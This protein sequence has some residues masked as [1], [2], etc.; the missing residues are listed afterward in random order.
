MG[1]YTK[2]KL[3]LQRLKDLDS[4]YIEVVESEITRCEEQEFLARLEAQKQSIETGEFAEGEYLGN[5][6]MALLSEDYDKALLQA[7]KHLQDFP[8]DV[9]GQ[10]ILGQ[11][12]QGLSKSSDA[13]ATFMRIVAEHPEQTDALFNLGN[14]FLGLGELEKSLG[15]F[16]KV[17]ELDAEY[18]FIKENI[19]S[20]KQKVHA[21][22]SDDE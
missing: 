13:I 17:A 15:Y 4:T 2:A 12:L 10:M 7:E 8:D 21:S 5:A 14:I 20:I 9:Q 19:A 3:H 1:E 18:P 22:E 11:A 6:L 16:S